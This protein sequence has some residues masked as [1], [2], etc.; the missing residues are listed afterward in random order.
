MLRQLTRILLIALA[1][2][3]GVALLA[4]AVSAVA[5]RR[6]PRASADPA[7]LSVAERARPVSYTH[8]DVYKR[9]VLCGAGGGGE[10]PH[11]AAGRGG[12]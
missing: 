10:E 12:G 2:L 1:I 7:R 4:A 5:N 8:L 9:Q 3:F 11:F 6:L